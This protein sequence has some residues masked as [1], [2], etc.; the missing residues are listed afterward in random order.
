MVSQSLRATSG[1]FRV[2]GLLP[3]T[4]TAV[5]KTANHAP[6]SFS[7]VVGDG[8][9][10]EYSGPCFEVEGA[11]AGKLVDANGT[12]VVR[13]RLEIEYQERLV[14]VGMLEELAT[15]RKWTDEGG[16][17]EVKGLVP[18]A[19]FWLRFNGIRTVEGPFVVDTGE[20]RDLSEVTAPPA[21]AR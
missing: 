2:D 11:V 10:V 21:A 9:T 19:P 15:G 18:R 8:D 20:R 17:F 16:R 5:L 3:G 14:E 7:L 13:A 6:V 4:V 12:P 1:V